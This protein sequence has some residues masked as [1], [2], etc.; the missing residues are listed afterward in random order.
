MPQ[1]EP[2]Y[3]HDY[4]RLDELLGTQQPVS[5]QHGAEAHDEMLFIVVHQVYELWFKQILHEFR[6]VVAIFEDGIVME[7]EMGALLG[8]LE[9]VVE[10]QRL[11][12]HQIDVLETMTPLDFLDF[13]DLLMPASGF[14][15]VQFRLIENA[16]GVRPDQ[17]V[18][19]NEAYYT[20][21]FTDAHR[22]QL[23]ASEQQ[24]SLH[25][26]VEAW[27]ARTPF[28]ETD[29][30]A[31]WDEYQ[32]AVERMLDRERIALQSNDS[33][34][35]QIRESQLAGL[36]RN[37]QGYMPLYDAD[38]WEALV[39][40]GSRRF[41]RRAFMAALLINLYRDEPIL[42]LPFRLLTSLSDIDEGFITWRQR[43]GLMVMRMIGDRIGTGGTSGHEYLRQAA[44]R[45]RVFVDL[46][47]VPT[48]LIPRSELPP[49]PPEVVATMRFGTTP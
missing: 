34:S 21:R 33:L 31:F 8:H 43:H 14:E 41:S 16:L 47:Q 32:A 26:Y 25:D 35:E 3:Y 5:S 10:I 48:F 37:R 20:E 7:R 38:A 42:Q 30:F 27:L 39:E 1:H 17:R 24:P 2:V 19:I 28:L 40:A 23:E 12:V 29:K 22:S 11:L 4:L 18:R 13:R 49:L 36:D 15:S 44:E 46:V 9:R 6:A 45:S